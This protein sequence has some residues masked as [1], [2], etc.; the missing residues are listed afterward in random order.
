MTLASIELNLEGNNLRMGG[1]A[2]TIFFDDNNHNILQAS[3]DMRYNTAVNQGHRFH[4]DGSLE[5]FFDAAEAD[6][7]GNNI[8]NAGFLESADAAPAQS[9]AIRLGNTETIVG[10]NTIDTIDIVLIGLTTANQIR[11]G[12]NL[13]MEVKNINNVGI[14]GQDGA[15]A[16]VG[17]IRMRNNATPVGGLAWRNAAGSDNIV[18][19]VNGSDDFTWTIS[20]TLEMTL[21]SIALTLADAVDI[22]VNATTGTKIGTA[23]AQKIG[24]WNATPIVQEAH[25][26]DPSGGATIDAE[27]RTAINAI[28]AMLAATGLTAA[29]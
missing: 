19:D 1:V 8:R 15:E 24:F 20:G 4:V 7:V 14:V 6:F 18:L 22:V 12:S 11:F 25:I 5:Y 3:G 28:N 26:A 10:R 13:D 23:T 17:F 27:A 2:A 16:S 9:G 21:S 29:S